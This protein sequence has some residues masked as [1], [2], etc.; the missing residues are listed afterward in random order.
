[1]LFNHVFTV[2]IATCPIH[3]NDCVTYFT[4]RHI[5]IDITRW[6]KNEMKTITMVG[7]FL[8][9]LKIFSL[10]LKHSKIR[11]IKLYIYFFINLDNRSMLGWSWKNFETKIS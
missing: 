6:K 11:I 10:K 2:I 3:F 9:T 7:Q 5:W 1:M 8:V 4:V